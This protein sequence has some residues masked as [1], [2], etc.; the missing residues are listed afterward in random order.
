M[1]SF[2]G[3]RPGVHQYVSGIDVTG[4]PFTYVVPL[5]SLPFDQ[6][7]PNLFQGDAFNRIHVYGWSPDGQNYLVASGYGTDYNL[8]II[9]AASGKISY[10]YQVANEIEPAIL[11]HQNA[12]GIEM[13]WPSEP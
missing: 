13:V 8:A 2:F 12:S 4:H 6:S 9:H 10:Q 7:D 1:R 5:V 11:I 3:Q